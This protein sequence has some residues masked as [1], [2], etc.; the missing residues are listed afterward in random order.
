MIKAQSNKECYKF[1][2][3]QKNAAKKLLRTP[4]ALSQEKKKQYF[5]DGGSPKFTKKL[6][7]RIK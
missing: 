5:C 1:I 4:L 2:K 3:I 7:F 6:R